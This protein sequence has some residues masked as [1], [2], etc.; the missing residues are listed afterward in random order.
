MSTMEAILEKQVNIKMKNL[1][2]IHS[3][4]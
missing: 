3:Q 4:I 2:K 1:T